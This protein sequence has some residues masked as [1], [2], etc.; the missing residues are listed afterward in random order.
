M[1]SKEIYNIKK[2]QTKS[3]DLSKTKKFHNKNKMKEI[4]TIES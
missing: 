1:K 3:K 4:I 2:M